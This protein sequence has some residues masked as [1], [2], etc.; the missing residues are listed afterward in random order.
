MGFWT[1]KKCISNSG[2][3]FGPSVI[4]FQ[5]TAYLGVEVFQNVKDMAE[6]ADK[7]PEFGMCPA[8]Y[9]L[10]CHRKGIPAS[11]M[12]VRTRSSF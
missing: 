9:G 7:C 12:I 4:F 1:V 6:I 11:K 10:E 5:R 2:R 8:A 3:S